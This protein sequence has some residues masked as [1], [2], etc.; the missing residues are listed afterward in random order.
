MESPLLEEVTVVAKGYLEKEM[1]KVA[2]YFREHYAE[3][4]LA[5][6]TTFYTV[7]CNG[8]YKEFTGYHGLFRSSRFT[9]KAP[10]IFFNDRNGMCGIEPLTTMRSDRL[11]A[12]SD[13]LL[14]PESVISR[15]LSWRDPK[16]L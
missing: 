11:R 14:E 5:T 7:E 16:S 2:R 13:E 9:Q 1:E 12:E 10:D 8:K 3:D 4:Y 6:I 15:Q